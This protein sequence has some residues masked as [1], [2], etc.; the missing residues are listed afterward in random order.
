M[1]VLDMIEILPPFGKYKYD[2][3][4]ILPVKCYIDNFMCLRSCI[5]NVNT[6]T[7]LI[8][9]HETLEKEYA[10]ASNLSSCVDILEKDN[11][12]LKAQL[13][14]LTS[15]HVKMQKDYEM[16]KCSHEDLQDVHVMLQ[17]SHEVVVT[18]VK[19]FQPHAQEC[20]CSPNIVNSICA[21]ACCS[22]SQQSNIE[23]INADSCD[24]LVAEENGLL[25]LEVQRLESEM[26]K[27]K[28]KTLGQPTQ[29][30]RDHIVNKLELKTT[31]TRSSSQQ[32][33]KSPHHK[34]QE[35]EKEDLKHIKCFKCYN[36]G[37]Y[38]FMCSAQIE[39]KTRLPRRQRRQLRSITCFGCKKEAHKI[40]ACPNF[41]T[42]RHCSGRTDQTGLAMVW[43][44]KKS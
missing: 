21:N 26:V 30:N 44:P 2:I 14:V 29:D 19:H 28:G 17:V 11:T 16:L 25:K 34:K 1:L 24:D 31:I 40:Q 18:S 35:K 23:Q 7:S 5:R 13:E 38:A 22:Q 15:K 36:M 20:T 4:R 33:Y 6:H 32:N 37:H 39:S 9:K 42:E 27:L 3:R 12:D 10:C 41:Q 8:D 43:L